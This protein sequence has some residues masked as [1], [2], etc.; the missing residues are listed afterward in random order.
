[1]KSATSDISMSSD[2]E[3]E[4]ESKNSQDSSSSSSDIEGGEDEMSELK[5]S[6][7]VSKNQESAS[8]PESEDCI[9]VNRER[10]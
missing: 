5:R 3:V 9:A 10:R 4:S 8:E 6:N 7:E 1:M 2:Q